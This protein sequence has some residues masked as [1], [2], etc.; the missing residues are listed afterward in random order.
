MC[1]LAIQYYVHGHGR[2]HASR[3]RGVLRALAAE[4]HRVSVVVSGEAADLVGDGA[5]L[6]RRPLLEPGPLAVAR[7]AARAV[8]EAAWLT[9]RA[10]DV[11][12][13]DGDQP[14]LLAARRLGLPTL[15]IGHD[16]VFTACRLPPGVSLRRVLYQR[17]N[18]LVPTHLA[19]ARVAV[20]FLP[21]IAR[22]PCT[23]VARPDDQELPESRAGE[24]LVAYFSELDAGPIL[25]RLAATGLR[26]EWFGGDPTRAPA[27]VE[28]R[29]FGRDAF[30]S[31][32]ATARGVVGSAGSNLLAEAVLLQKPLLC[33][34]DPRHMEQALNAELVARSGVGLA[35]PA[36]RVDD[37]LVRRFVDMAGAG[38][39]A[40]VDLVGAL[41]TVSAAARAWIRALA[42]RH[43]VN[44]RR[45][46]PC[47][48]GA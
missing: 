36:A 43:P 32:L 12:V 2:G 11:V 17:A 47:A 34:Y 30:V 27:G 44:H 7:L 37:A 45:G 21:M 35:A 20:G 19:D 18:A 42:A 25:E 33:A 28:A 29:P 24:H 10:V 3:A 48:P 6:E 41:P 26:V 40:R 22:A 16:L 15:A 4:G 9:T 39:H 8:A 14:S 13:S 46:R 31:S 1:P 23:T 38:T 5:P